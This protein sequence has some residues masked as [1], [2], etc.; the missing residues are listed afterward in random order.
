MNE[1][2]RLG[3]TTLPLLNSYPVSFKEFGDGG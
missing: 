2:V 3:S 1:G